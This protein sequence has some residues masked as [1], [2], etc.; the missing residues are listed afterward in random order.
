M[1]WTN[2]GFILKRQLEEAQ[3]DL[4]G[5]NVQPGTYR[6]GERADFKLLAGRLM[7]RMDEET[8]KK[9]N[10]SVLLCE[11]ASIQEIHRF[12]E[13][14]DITQFPIIAR[15]LV[16]K[17]VMEAF[18]A[19][20]KIGD[21]LV[22]PLPSKHEL[23]RIP[24][25]DVKSNMRDI[26]PGMPYHH[27]ADI[28]EKYVTIEGKKRGDILDITE[29]AILFDQTGLVLREAAR[30]GEQAAI[31]R[32]KKIMYTIQ[33]ATVNNVNYYA[34]FPSGT[35]V[36]LYSGT[37]VVTHPYSNLIDHALQHWTDLDHAKTQFTTFRDVN[38]E[39]IWVQPKILLVPLALETVA[40]R[41]I[42]NTLLP[43]AR[44]GQTVVGDSPMEANPFANKYTV[45]ASPYMDI[46]STTNWYLGDFKRQFLEKIIYPIQVLTR[47]DQKNDYAWERDIVAQYK[48]RYY[49]HPGAVDYKYVVKSRGTYGTCPTE[50]YC[51][52]WDEASVP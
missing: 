30:F 22:T 3:N 2:K 24:G 14:V 25:A 37:V 35:R 34:F 23:S 48:I 38:L 8:A 33:D 40:E 39:P 12:C 16:E 10:F 50:S 45:L 5:A 51:S 17:K 20:P 49:T 15:T 43:A 42:K 21:Q 52:S 26:E 13:A 31:D 4:K 46:V 36:A 6:K 41:L 7:R 28:E 29:E 18:N 11:D 1:S 27:D 47:K 32:E 19:F 9:E 44:V